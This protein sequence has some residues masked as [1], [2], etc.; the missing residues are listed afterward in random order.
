MGEKET[1]GSFVFESREAYDR[2]V[3]E[4][5]VIQQLR[6]KADISNPK[7]ALKVYNKSVADKLFE[8]VIGYNFLYY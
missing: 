3:Q 2:A 5:E 6:K 1:I 8:T 4:A 7:T